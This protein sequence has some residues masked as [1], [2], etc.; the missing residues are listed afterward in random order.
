M[1]RTSFD[2]Q[3][4]QETAQQESRAGRSG[5]RGPR[6]ERHEGGHAVDHARN[7][8]VGRN[9]GAQLGAQ[10]RKR[11]YVMLGAAAGIGF[12]AGSLFGSRLGQ[13]AIAAGIGYVAKN[14]LEGEMDLESLRQN[15]ERL[16]QERGKA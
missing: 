5:E 2:E 8:E 1:N 11:P 4:D 12:V 15:I 3:K 7:R 14:M 16:A 10:A 6:H 9:L 13:I